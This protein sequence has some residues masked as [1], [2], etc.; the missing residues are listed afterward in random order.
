MKDFF[1]N[2]ADEK[3]KRRLE[4]HRNFESQLTHYKPRKRKEEVEIKYLSEKELNRFFKAI[5]KS[6]NKFRLRDL[7]A[8]TIIY[9]C[10]LRASELK[11]IKLSDLNIETGDIYIR[12]LKGSNNNTL[13]LYR[14]WNKRLIKDYIKEYS[15]KALYQINGENDYLFKGKNWKPLDL[16]ALRY[17]MKEYW[18]LAGLPKEKQHPHILKHT[19]AVNLANRKIDLKGL[20]YYLGHKNVNNTTIYYQFTSKQYEDLYLSL[21]KEGGLLDDTLNN[22]KEKN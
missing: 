17:L 20:Q 1:Y 13:N 14:V 6:N 11:L 5:E 12:R 10:G 18:S 21:E 4:Q 22:K 9:L 15:G 19:I 3:A 8:F 7:T 2:E 16:E